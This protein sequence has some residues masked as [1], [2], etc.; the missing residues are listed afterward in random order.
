MDGIGDACDGLIVN[1]VLSPNG[2]FINDTWTIF[3]IER[4]PDATVK[5]YNRWGNEVFASKNYN[6]DWRG[7]SDGKTLPQGSYFYQVNPGNGEAILSGWI[8][9]TY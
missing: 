7:D 5:V 6:N 2:D 9:L 4:Y 3:N 8:Y 1:D